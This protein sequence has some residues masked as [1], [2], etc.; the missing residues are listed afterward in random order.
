MS[1]LVR[2]LT[3]ISVVLSPSCSKA[4]CS[5]SG[6]QAGFTSHAAC[7][8]QASKPAPVGSHRVEVS[9]G[10]GGRRRRGSIARTIDVPSGDQSTESTEARRAIR[11]G[12]RNAGDRRPRGAS[13]RRHRH[14]TLDERG[15]G[16]RPQTSVGSTCTP[17]RTAVAALST[18]ALVDDDPDADG[19]RV[20]GRLV[21]VDDESVARRSVAR[22]I[23]GRDSPERDDAD[24]K[25]RSHPER[26]H[27]SFSE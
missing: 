6:D 4:I 15:A 18:P 14:L 27:P 1:V 19:I 9:A 8:R 10:T 2:L 5:P 23:S 12:G 17:D 7:R 20:P 24:E 13:T 11:R 22:G 21:D 16:D 25:R 3:T 26:S